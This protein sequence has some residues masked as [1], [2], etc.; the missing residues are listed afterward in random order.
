MLG[1]DVLVVN[2]EE[3]IFE[4]AESNLINVHCPTCNAR[5]STVYRSQPSL[6]IWAMAMILFCIFPIFCCLPFCMTNLYKRTHT[7][8]RCQTVLWSKN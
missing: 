6:F 1:A 4:N 8:T 3:A 2:S 5:T 7:C